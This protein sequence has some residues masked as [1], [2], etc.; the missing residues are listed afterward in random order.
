MY[1]TLMV[2]V[3]ICLL[4]LS[5]CSTPKAIT[6]T[7]LAPPNVQLLQ[8]IAIKAIATASPSTCLEN[9]E[10]VNTYYGDYS[11]LP[12]GGRTNVMTFT[13]GFRVKGSNREFEESGNTIHEI[14]QIEV[15]IGL[16]GRIAPGDVASLI[17]CTQV[18][19]KGH[20]TTTT[21]GH[22]PLGKLAQPFYPVGSNPQLNPP[23]RVALEAIARAAIHKAMPELKNEEIGF[24]KIWYEHRATDPLFMVQFWILSSI[25]TTHLNPGVRIDFDQISVDFVVDD[26]IHFEKLSKRPSRMQFSD[27]AQAQ[28]I[29]N[30]LAE[31][32]PGIYSSK[33]ADGL[34]EKAQD[35]PSCASSDSLA[36]WQGRQTTNVSWVWE[37]M[38]PGDPFVTEVKPKPDT[39]VFRLSEKDG[40]PG[41]VKALA[42]AG[43]G[44]IIF[45]TRNGL[46]LWHDGIM[47][48]YTGP[49]GS[50]DAIRGEINDIV[51]TA[52]GAI[53]IATSSGV[54]RRL[55]NKWEL[56]SPKALHSSSD[57]ESVPDLQ[58]IQR[59]FV[60]SN[61]KLI[62][63]T[64]MA[65]VMIVDSK[66]KTVTQIHRDSDINHWVTG[67]A[68]DSD[69]NI[70]I[71]IKGIGVLKY[72]WEKVAVFSEKEDWIPSENIRSLCVSHDDAVWVGTHL[73]LGV[74]YSN[75]RTKVFRAADVLPDDMIWDLFVRKNGDVW[76]RSDKGFAVYDGNAWTYPDFSGAVGPYAGSLLESR[77]G[78]LW[79][80][81]WNGVT[82][83]PKLQFSK[84]NPTKRAFTELKKKIESNYPNVEITRHIAKDGEGRI[85]VYISSKLMRYDGKTWKDLSKIH[86]DNE[87]T[88]VKTDSLKRVWVGTSGAGLIGYTK[89]EV[90]RYHN[91]QPGSS[92]SGIY[93]LVEHPTGDL[94]VGT[95][96]GLYRLSGKKWE[97]ITKELV[98]N[99]FLQPSNIVLDP[100]K[101]VYFS[102]INNGLFRFDGKEVKHLWKTDITNLNNS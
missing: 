52:N 76:A 11:G 38:A 30:R 59:L 61:D 4:G 56:I 42:E 96:N 12:F 93:A 71:S 20:E 72:D 64:R 33:A 67:I 21:R 48:T 62:V 27:E 94:Y 68:E 10:Y 73:G 43:D 29:L 90:S 54:V 58:D 60:A 81:D 75:G 77:S 32:A 16:D 14:D 39:G 50:E 19:S 13:V 7:Q 2:V 3:V 74:R 15:T 46:S 23:D 95:Q 83:N 88:F 91:N 49:G 97:N 100:E 8:D 24:S 9:L 47:T 37:R 99:L 82:K 35:L 1:R 5:S 45:G 28:K 18:N 51:T 40:L 31:Q 102:D 65:G 98:P 25:R 22:R 92:D 79:I 17:F 34:A 70:W 85:W 26:V 55:N 63:G 6:S 87:V 86:G 36:N 78:D 53:W 41:V 69:K 89:D 80:A 101:R 57:R 66:D 44:T 84:V